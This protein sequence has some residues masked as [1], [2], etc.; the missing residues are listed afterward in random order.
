MDILK[1]I[2]EQKK[3]EITQHKLKLSRLDLEGMPYFSRKSQSLSENI[4][5]QNFGVIAEIKRKSPSR[6][7]INS[8]VIPKELSE[9]YAAAGVAGI[10]ILTDAPFFGGSLEDLNDVRS[11]VQ[12]PLL[13]KDFIIDEYQL[14]EAK[15]YGA[16]AILLIAEALDKK[17]LHELALIAN[18]LGM[19]VLMELHSLDQLDKFNEEVSILGVNN[20]DL[21]TQKTSI[22]TSIDLYSYLPSS[23]VKI[24]ESGI[25]DAKELYKLN[26]IGYQGALIGTSIVGDKNPGDKIKALQQFNSIGH[27]V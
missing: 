12:T 27:E 22:Q 10:S 11:V 4:S 14:F 15:A 21:K 5:N 19:E 7:S 1:K 2:I 24:T 26:K 13:R 6:G 20:R 25:T 9:K 23:V 16:D 18:S 3:I 8:T 17:H